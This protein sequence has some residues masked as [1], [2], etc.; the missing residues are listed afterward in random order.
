MNKQAF[1][2]YI[3]SPVL[4]ARNLAIK[5]IDKF[6]FSV[7]KGLKQ[8]TYAGFPLYVYIFDEVSKNWYDH[9]WERGE[10]EFLKKGKLKQGV[11]VFDIGAHHG[12]VALIFSK[13]VGKKGHVIAIEMDKNHIEAARVNKKSNSA[14]NLRLV[15]AAAAEKKR[16]IFY[17]KDQVQKVKKASNLASVTSISIDELTENFGIPSV[18]YIDVEGFECKVMEGAKK[19][20]K[21]YPDFCIEVHAN[22]GL[23]NFGGS[24]KQLLSYFPKEKYNIFISAAIHKCK[25]QPLKSKS[26]LFKDRFYLIA[27]ARK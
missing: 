1:K 4:T 10:I 6:F 12:I 20:L 27:L 8:H 5:I 26:T 11:T 16:R 7:T 23:E 25:F 18:L 24:V 19:T 2:K 3:P 22:N 9:D 21:Y 14:V 15:H 17:A 13:I